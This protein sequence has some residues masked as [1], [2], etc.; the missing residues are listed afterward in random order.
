MSKQELY[1]EVWRDGRQA[2]YVGGDNFPGALRY[3]MQYGKN[4]PVK[5][6]KVIREVVYRS[7]EELK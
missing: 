2:A 1:Y 6:Y 5:I 7:T 4:G 3:A